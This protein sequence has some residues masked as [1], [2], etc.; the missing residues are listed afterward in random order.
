MPPS[1]PPPV[2]NI[3]QEFVGVFLQHVPPGL[4]PIRGIAHQ[5]DL[6]PGASFPNRVP[7]RTNP[8]ET[9]EIQQQIQKLLENS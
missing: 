7:H 6:I 5:I 8:E 3:L 1:L 4:P 2:V 9:K